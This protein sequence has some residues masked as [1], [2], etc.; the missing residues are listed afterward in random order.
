MQIT[1]TIRASSVAS[2]GEGDGPGSG[3]ASGRLPQHQHVVALVQRHLQRRL[4][5]VLLQ[6]GTPRRRPDAGHHHALQPRPGRVLGALA[7]EPARNN[8]VSFLPMLSL[9]NRDETDIR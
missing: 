4:P 3:H 8:V 1:Y 9:E 5:P 2:V 6:P 7:R